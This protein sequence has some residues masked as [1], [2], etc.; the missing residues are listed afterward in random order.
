MLI[1]RIPFIDIEYQH[2]EVVLLDAKGLYHINDLQIC[3]EQFI[4]VAL[5]HIWVVFQRAPAHAAGVR[6]AHLKW[7]M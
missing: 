3:P 4:T 6:T 5:E 2:D 7:E 1:E